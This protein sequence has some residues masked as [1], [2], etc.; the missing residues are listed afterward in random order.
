[1]SPEKLAFIEL[2]P[3]RPIACH[4]ADGAD[5]VVFPQDLFLEGRAAEAPAEPPF[6]EVPAT[7][8]GSGSIE[9]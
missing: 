3:C 9:A 4:P 2:V 7:A 6:S 5:E 1:M 8:R